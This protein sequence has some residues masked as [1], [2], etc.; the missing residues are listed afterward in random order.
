M[1]IDAN[2][3][4]DGRIRTAHYSFCGE[5]RFS[6]VEETR[7]GTLITE[8]RS[9]GEVLNQVGAGKKRAEEALAEYLKGI[10]ELNIGRAKGKYVPVRVGAECAKCRGG[11][12]REL[13]LKCPGEI[14]SVPVVPMFVCV[15]CGSRYYHLTDEYLIRLVR[16]NAA[17]FDSEEA[18]ERGKDEGEFVKTLQEYVIRIFASKRISKLKI[19]D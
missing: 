10:G 5:M 11:I 2:G 13:D 15:G 4:D 12:A 8:F 7:A 16:S 14:K 9:N 3:S 1:R 6:L 17:L 19:S 18:R